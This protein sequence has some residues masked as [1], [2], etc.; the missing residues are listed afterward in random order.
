MVSEQAMENS[1]NLYLLLADILDYPSPALLEQ[2]KRCGALL[3]KIDRDVVSKMDTFRLFVETTP[4]TR[5]QEVYTSTFDL[6]AICYPYAGYHLFGES[7][8]RGEFL[9][10]LKA[11]YSAVGFSS[12]SELPDHVPMLLRYLAQLQNDDNDDEREVIISECLL[13]AVTQMETRLRGGNP[14]LNVLQNLLTVMQ[15]HSRQQMRKKERKEEQR[16]KEVDE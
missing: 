16:R 1:D 9:A 3:G 8:R 12:G 2:V 11:R 5:L 4:L 7:Y 10:K 6:Q 15:T 13:P 14:Y